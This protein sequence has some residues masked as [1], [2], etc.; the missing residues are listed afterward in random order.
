MDPKHTENESLD[1]TQVT[2]ASD[3]MKTFLNEIANKDE[4]G[5]GA[6]GTPSKEAGM[7]EEGVG[8]EDI[9]LDNHADDIQDIEQNESEDEGID[10][11]RIGG[12]HPIHIGEVLQD[13]YVVIQKLGW[14][15][16]STVWLC[17]D[18]KYDTYVAVKCQ[19]SASNYMEAAFDE[20]EILQTAARFTNHPDWLE[21]LK[22]YYRDEN[23]TEFTRDDCHVVQLLNSFIYQGP[24]GNHFCMVFEIMGVNLLEI[25]KRYNYKGVPLHLVKRM[26]KQILIGLDYIHRFCKIIHTDLKPENILLT[27][28]PEEIT[29]I[30]ENGQL[31]RNKE[32]E[33]RIRRY[34]RKYNIKIEPSSTNAEDASG[35]KDTTDL[36]VTKSKTADGVSPAGPNK[37]FLEDAGADLQS[38]EKPKSKAK[39][40]GEAL[41]KK[42]LKLSENFNLKIVDLGNACWTHHHFSKEIQTRQY[43]S[44]EVIFGVN[45][46]TSA[47]IW[48]AACTIFEMLTGDFLFEPKKGKNYDKD[49]DH[50]AQM[51][52]LISKIPK[53]LALSGS[54]AKRYFTKQGELKNI[55]SFTHWPLKNV[56]SDKYHI[57]DQE[58][59]LLSGFLLPMLVYYPWK[60]ATAQECLRNPWIWAPVQDP[61]KL[62]P[63]EIQ[64]KLAQKN[65]KALE[66]ADFSAVEEIETEVNDASSEFTEQDLDEPSLSFDEEHDN[67]G[68][69]NILNRSYEK[70]G[71]IPWGGGIQA[72]EL[73]QDP[74]WQ[75]I[76]V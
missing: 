68:Y 32:I 53:K 2:I 3:N 35:K 14:G 40:F 62:T 56:L 46:D 63:Q 58:A 52:E 31:T 55:K 59:N 30:V 19:K 21:S 29:D 12:Y 16:F 20:V 39:S 37:V 76:D 48:S 71:Y 70:T 24:Y 34:Q 23:R 28:L 57:I 33:D 11:Y 60:R 22:E 6:E 69:A 38:P 36:K 13:R 64:I 27:L 51:I 67:Y 43:R 41:K 42:D 7:H 25:I 4:N 54:E 18:F 50:L 8:E 74:N 65:S 49:D 5:A 66:N 61:Y 72:D 17:K 15:H 47:D 10:D 45:Y 73:D 44:P 9:E 26:A 75:F 1:S